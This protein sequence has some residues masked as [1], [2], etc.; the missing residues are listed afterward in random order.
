VIDELRSTEVVPGRMPGLHAQ[1]RTHTMGFLEKHGIRSAGLLGGRGRNLGRP[2]LPYPGGRFRP[3]GARLDHVSG[4][5]APRARRLPVVT[6]QSW[7]GYAARSGHPR[8][9][10]MR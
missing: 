7:P 1:F 8:L 6:A 10:P 5:L 9:I 2:A 4:R 3:P